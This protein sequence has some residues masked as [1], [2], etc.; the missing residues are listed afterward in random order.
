MA[1]KTDLMK[2]LWPVAL[3]AGIAASAAGLW[4]AAPGASQGLVESPAPLGMVGLSEEETL[5][6]SIASVA[7]FDP[8]PDPPRCLLRAGFVDEEGNAIGNPGIFELRPGAS[9]SFDLPATRAGDVG[10]VYVRPVVS[11][12]LPRQNCPAVV[13]TEVLGRDGATSGI[14]IHYTPVSLQPWK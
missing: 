1:V 4:L 6:V 3:V 14:I 10:R 11:D 13:T 9:R 7:G 8:Q 5:R 2:T 12:L